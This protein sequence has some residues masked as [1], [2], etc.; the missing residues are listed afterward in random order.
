MKFEK[1]Y[2][3]SGTFSL[4]SA[5]SSGPFF[6]LA[7]MFT[8][9]AFSRYWYLWLVV[10][11]L[12]VAAVTGFRETIRIP[13]DTVTLS[14]PCWSVVLGCALFLGLAG[15]THQYLDS[16]QF[17]LA[18]KWLKPLHL[19]VSLTFCVLLFVCM[20]MALARR[21]AN[22]RAVFETNYQH[23]ESLYDFY[24]VIPGFFLLVQVLFLVALFR[25]RPRNV[26]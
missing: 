12:L 14:A 21:L 19:C 22:S 18:P 10:L 2:T 15:L 13:F 3:P 6:K 26:I 9:S 17:L 16:R 25:A 5:L 1:L 24:L 11:V 8:L 20:E 4:W 7:L 23:Y